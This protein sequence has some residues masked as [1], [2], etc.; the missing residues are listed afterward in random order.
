MKTLCPDIFVQLP[1]TIKNRFKSTILWTIFYTSDFQRGICSLLPHSAGLFMRVSFELSLTVNTQCDWVGGLFVLYL[2]S[3]SSY[4]PETPAADLHALEQQRANQIHFSALEHRAHIYRNK[5]SKI[6]TVKVIHG[7]RV[8]T[9]RSYKCQQLHHI[10]QSSPPSQVNIWK[11]S[12]FIIA[13]D[14]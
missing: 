12:Q 9:W 5:Q 14:F 3:Q 8:Q 6:N 1:L 13:A 2:F 7:T 11:A 10:A 4:S